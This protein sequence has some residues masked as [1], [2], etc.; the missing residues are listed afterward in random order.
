[1]D[2]IKKR[3][4]IIMWSIC[5]IVL[6]F[7]GRKNVNAAK[8]NSENA[9]LLYYQAFLICPK[10]DTTIEDLIIDTRQEQLF[11][12]LCGGE[13]EEYTELEEQIRELEENQKN[14][15]NDPNEAVMENLRQLSKSIPGYKQKLDMMKEGYEL[16]AEKQLELLKQRQ[17]F[18]RYYEPNQK[19]GSY[20]KDCRDAIEVAQAASEMSQC[21][22]GTQCIK[23]TNIIVSLPSVEA[24]S[25][26]FI[27]RADA[28][29]QAAY[30]DFHS[31]FERCMMMRRFARHIG[32]DTTHTY[33]ISRNVDLIS[34]DC[35]RFLLGKMEPDIDTLTWLKN[36]LIIHDG[37]TDPL[38]SIKTS[39]IELELILQAIRNGDSRKP[40]ILRPRTRDRMA[41]KAKDEITKNKIKSMPVDQLI[42]YIRKPYTEFLD[43]VNEVLDSDMSYEKKDVRI[44]RYLNEYKESAKVNPAIILITEIQAEDVLNFYRRQI[45]NIAHLNAV[46]AAIEIYLIYIEK[47]RLPVKLPDGLPKDPYSDK[48]FE[49]ELTEKGFLFRCR[50]KPVNESEVRHYEFKVQ[51]EN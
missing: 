43:S 16:E 50:I 35:I 44:E 45:A 46:R 51:R 48:D 22:W 10:P 32:N 38:L 37:M 2:M 8:T 34:L 17:E 12:V 23:G 4:F 36:Q 31:A 1:M 30:L 3:N 41:N 42:E 40:S 15:V 19:I 49:Y 33:M 11:E 20:L 29:L 18:I 14:N 47:G 25:F 26:G 7:A 28:L 21:D 6:F 27:L 9:A 39:K 24:R 13:L 5:I